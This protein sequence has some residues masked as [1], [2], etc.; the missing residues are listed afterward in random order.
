MKKI[1]ALIIMLLMTISV[2]ARADLQKLYDGLGLNTDQKAKVSELVKRLRFEYMEYLKESSAAKR[3]QD[4]IRYSPY[5][6]RKEFDATVDKM[7]ELEIQWQKTL[8]DHFFAVKGILNRDQ[9]EDF[10]DD[11]FDTKPF[12]MPGPGFGKPGEGDDRMRGGMR[13]PDEGGEGAPPDMGGRS[14][15]N[16]GSGGMRGG[17]P[18][19]MKDLGV[20]GFLVLT[21][22]QQ[23]VIKKILNEQSSEKDNADDLLEDMNDEIQ[24]MMTKA[25]PDRDAVYQKVEQRERK[26]GDWEK[27]SFSYLMRAMQ[28]LTDDQ[29]SD[30]YDR[31]TNIRDGM[32]PGGD[33]PYMAEPREPR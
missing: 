30:L 18:R 21:K 13:R 16:M 5:T 11:Y 26:K 17:G 31:M 25:Q 2:A 1:G 6:T 23:N 24:S 27:I 12:D 22:D 9:W 15:G 3:N 28:I 14:G 7:T 10:T 20:F 8:L 32:R 19:E 4:E 29:R 33:N